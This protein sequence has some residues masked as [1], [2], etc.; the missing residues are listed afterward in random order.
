MAVKS[1]PVIRIGIHGP[2]IHAG[3]RHSAGLWPAGVANS[4]TYAEAVPVILP[5]SSERSW[6][7]VLE[8]I[9]GVVVVGHDSMPRRCPTDAESLC[10]WCH[11]HNIPLLAIDQGILLLNSSHGGTLHNDLP[12]DLPEALQHRHPPERGLR[13]AINVL[14]GTHLEKLYGEGEVVVNSEHRRAIARLARGFRVSAQALDGVVEAIEATGEWY[15]L[16]VQWNAASPTSTGLDIQ[17]F[18]GVINAC[19]ARMQTDDAS[20]QVSGGKVMRV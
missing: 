10:S 3:K 11:D 7:E 5:Q 20:K 18:R 13:H 9:D 17:L 6:G 16:G 15:A 12:R 1:N 2:D 14:P 8:G 19:I 4:I